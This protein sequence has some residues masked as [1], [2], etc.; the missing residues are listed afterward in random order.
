MREKDQLEMTRRKE[1]E[2][3]KNQ[4]LG[5]KEWAERVR[6]IEE[7]KQ[8]RARLVEARERGEEVGTPGPPVVEDVVMMVSVSYTHL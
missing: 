5:G 6:A 2:E 7:R 4:P 8:E 1:E 3:R